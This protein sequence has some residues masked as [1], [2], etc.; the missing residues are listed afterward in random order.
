[1]DKK[2][3]DTT[4]LMMRQNQDLADAVATSSRVLK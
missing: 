3:G 4:V 1:M 2:L